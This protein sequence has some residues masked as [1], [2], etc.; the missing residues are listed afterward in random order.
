M[1]KKLDKTSNEKVE[2]EVTKKVAMVEKQKE[3]EKPTSKKKQ[4]GSFILEPKKLSAL[5]D[6]ITLFGKYTTLDTRTSFPLFDVIDINLDKNKKEI[7]TYATNSTRSALSRSRVK[8]VEILEQGEIK[9]GDD[10]SIIKIYE[11]SKLF[12]KRKTPTEIKIVENTFNFK[13]GNKNSTIKTKSTID[14]KSH[15][16]AL[17]SVLEATNVVYDNIEIDK[18]K[19]K[20]AKSITYSGAETSKSSTKACVVISSSDLMDALKDIEEVNV[21]CFRFVFEKN[22]ETGKISFGIRLEDQ[23][24]ND[25]ISSS[26]ETIFIN[27]EPMVLSYGS[28]V[29]PVISNMNGYITLNFVGDYLFIY[30]DNDNYE[31]LTGITPFAEIDDFD[32]DDLKSGEIDINKLENEFE[33]DETT[34]DAE[35]LE[36]EIESEKGLVEDSEDSKESEDEDEDEDSESEDETEEDSEK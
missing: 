34:E 8:G 4:G 21:V 14:I 32:D 12:S 20:F 27:A 23:L 28:G 10:D 22:A 16:E 2:A 30:N 17:K 3:D 24:G 9:L 18:E 36:K 35:K 33:E 5:V 26:I 7:I 25:I 31:I 29:Y 11:R 1:A 13:S 6:I 15:I 19:I